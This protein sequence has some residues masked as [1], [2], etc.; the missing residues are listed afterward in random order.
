MYGQVVLYYIVSAIACIL[1]IKAFLSPDKSKPSLNQIT[2]LTVFIIFNIATLAIFFGS[3]LIDVSRVLCYAIFA[4][5]ILNGL[6]IYD[7]GNN[8]KFIHKPIKKKVLVP[9]VT[10]FLI[11]S[12]IFGTFNVYFS[13]MVKG[14]N[15]QVPAMELQGM[16]W[17]FAFR[18]QEL[19]IDE[20]GTEQSRF[21]SALLGVGTGV[22]EKSNIRVR[23]CKPPDHFNYIQGKTLGQAYNRD[24]YLLITEL[25]RI[26]YPK[27]YP[28][29]P[30]YARYTEGDF[31][32]LEND[33]SVDKLYSN[34]NFEVRYIRSQKSRV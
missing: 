18:N 12:L 6:V 3:L 32:R 4:S 15:H 27:V 34:G 17:L 31:D 7:L 2:F 24:R 26:F 30:E 22:E 14:I 33:S 20:I 25:I 1:I 9:L 5:T 28:N 13:P 8:N 29:H 23:D 21:A 16:S 10:A 11:F 19:L